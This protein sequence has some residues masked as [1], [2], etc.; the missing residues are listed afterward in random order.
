MM[1]AGGSTYRKRR[2]AG[3]VIYIYINISR[4]SHEAVANGFLHNGAL[5][6]QPNNVLN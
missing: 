4:V 2:I 6:W 1:L 5:Y 3:W